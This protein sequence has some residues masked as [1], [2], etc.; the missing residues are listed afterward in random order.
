MAISTSDT[1]LVTVSVIDDDGC[2]NGSC[3]VQQ[4][5]GEL[6]LPGDAIALTPP[7]DNPY[8]TE[9][10]YH[11]NE[12]QT[13]WVSTKKPTTAAECVAFGTVSHTSQCARDI[14][15]RAL[16]QSLTEADSE[17][18]K[19]TRGE[20]LSWKVEAIPEKTI[21]EVRTDKLNELDRA[22]MQ[23]QSYNCKELYITSSLGFQANADQ[24]SQKN[25]EVLISLLPDDETTTTYKIYDNTF[26]EL[27]RVQLATLRT[28]CEQ[29][30]VNLYQQKFAYQAKIKSCS[31]IDEIKAITIE[32]VMMDFSKA[33]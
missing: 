6:L 23:Y 15:L 13:E 27:N 22:S 2:F 20:D 1:E 11:V 4:I 9:Y 31:T 16:F 30:G 24:C 29:N 32:F 8:D 7:A 21:E 25:M 3:L 14:I 19:I 5:G 33:E 10:F 17:H 18:Y 12:D 28:E 26:K